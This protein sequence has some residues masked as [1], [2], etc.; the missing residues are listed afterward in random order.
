M[1]ASNEEFRA[2][3]IALYAD[4]RAGGRAKSYTMLELLDKLDGEYNRINNL[5]RWIKREDPQ[6]LALT[7]TISNLQSQ[8]S[9]L[10]GQY[11]S[12]QALVARSTLPSPPAPTP[13]PIIGKLQKP[14]P[15]QNSEPEIQE[16]QAL[17]GS[18]ATN[19]SMA[20][21]TEHT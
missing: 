13:T 16:F 19:V 21:G 10:K 9:T 17:P 14:P 11:G 5:G 6:V 2:F 4:Y 12:L 3:V 8:L 20:P 1:E 18:V 15:K 7:A